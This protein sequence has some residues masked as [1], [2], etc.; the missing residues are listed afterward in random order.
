MRS[1]DG[2]PYN[3]YCKCKLKTRGTKHVEPSL[4]RFHFSAKGA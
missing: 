1:G 3:R 4:D 2:L